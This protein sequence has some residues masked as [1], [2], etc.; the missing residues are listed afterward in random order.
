MLVTFVTA[1][2]QSRNDEYNV[3]IHVWLHYDEYNIIMCE[4][5]SIMYQG[6]HTV[7]VTVRIKAGILQYRRFQYEDTV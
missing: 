1:E 5:T 2:L 7:W 4:L 6:Q 3:K